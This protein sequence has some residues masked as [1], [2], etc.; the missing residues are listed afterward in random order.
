MQGMFSCSK[1]AMERAM[2]IT[3]GQLAEILANYILNE[4]REHPSWVPV[5]FEKGC[6]LALSI[7]PGS[8]CSFFYHLLKTNL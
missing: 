2:K 6:K 4:K 5:R 3:W 1:A 7:L 8:R